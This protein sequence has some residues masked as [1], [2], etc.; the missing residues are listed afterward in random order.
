MKQYF[1]IGEIAELFDLN[2]RTLRYYDQID[3]VKPEFTDP[4][5]GYRYYSTAQFE[6]LNTIRYLRDLGMSLDDIRSFLRG[7]DTGAMQDM[8]RAQLD[9]VEQRQRDLDLIRRKL[10]MRLAQ[11]EKAL[12]DSQGTVEFRR[13]DARRAVR[14]RYS[15]SPDTDLEYPIR[16]LAKDIGVRGIFL[17]MVGLSISRQRL[18]S[19][20]FDNYD[21]IFLLLDGETTSE[22]A[23]GPQSDAAAGSTAARPQSDAA[24]RNTAAS[25]AEFAAGE[26]A[27]LRF[28]GTHAAAAGHYQTLH[29]EIHRKGYKICG[30]SLEI[31]L[32]DYGLTCDPENF[33]TELQIP[34]QKD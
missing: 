10:Q 26:Y 30:D 2:I 15:L 33:V 17:G 21:S 25:R 7:R 3:L 27:V 4:S 20:E 5:S 22:T 11:I 34:V 32:I 16:L 23:G 24:A 1:K 18:E 28:R 13:F 12:S 8:M 9:E 19:A 14:L 6:P 29:D 31:T